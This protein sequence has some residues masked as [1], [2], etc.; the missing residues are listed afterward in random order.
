LLNFF[1]PLSDLS[2]LETRASNP[3][4]LNSQGIYF[5][6]DETLVFRCVSGMRARNS[7]GKKLKSSEI[8]CTERA[9]KRPI[10]TGVFGSEDKAN[11]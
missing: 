6:T 2:S 1:S 10:D 7:F 11:I 4:P 8:F 3:F 5:R 9:L